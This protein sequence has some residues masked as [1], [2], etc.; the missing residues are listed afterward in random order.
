M[1]TGTRNGIT[2]GDYVEVTRRFKGNSNT[3]LVGDRG[4]VVEVDMDDITSG[5]FRVSNERVG[6][7][8]C[9]VDDVKLVNRTLDPGATIKAIQGDINTLIK[10]TNLN[11]QSEDII[12]WS[13]LDQEQKKTLYKNVLESLYNPVLYDIICK[14]VFINNK[15]AE[16][17]QSNENS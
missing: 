8:G 2:I 9:W 1:K 6:P 10:G 4:T 5:W 11:I 7:I 3:L 16:N 17:E 12:Q 15:T 13:E 14:L